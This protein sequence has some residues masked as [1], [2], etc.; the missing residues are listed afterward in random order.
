METDDGQ[1]RVFASLATAKAAALRFAREFEFFEF[2]KRGDDGHEDDEDDEDDE[3]A[4]FQIRE[5]GIETKRA[6]PYEAS[7]FRE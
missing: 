7:A 1:L 4:G 6:V 3:D 2:G 5:D